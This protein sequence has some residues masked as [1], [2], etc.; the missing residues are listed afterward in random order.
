MGI[1]FYFSNI[2]REH[3]DIV[4]STIKPGSKYVFLDFN[5]AIHYCNNAIKK[6]EDYSIDNHENMLITECLK[7]IDTIIEHSHCK[8]TLFVSI[9][10]VVPFSKMIQQRKRR[11]LSVWRNTQLKIN[12]WDSN[13]ISPGTAFMKR[14]NDALSEYRNAKVRNIIISDSTH[15]G[16]GEAKIFKFIKNNGIKNENIIIYGLDAD[17]IMLSLLQDNHVHLMRESEFYKFKLDSPFLYLDISMLKTELV[18]YIKMSMDNVTI[19]NHLQA[20][21]VLCYFIG[22][23]FIPSLSYLKIK[24]GSIDFMLHV[25]SKCIDQEGEELM[26]MNDD[27]GRWELNW[28]VF[29]KFI[30]YLVQF[31]DHEF[32]KNHHKYYNYSRKYTD[33]ADYYD[34]YGMFNKPDD[35]IRPNEDGW[36]HR[37]YTSLFP[38]MKVDSICKNYIEGIKW[39]IQYYFN[40]TC[41]T[42]WYYKYDYS[43]TLFD[44]SNYMTVNDVNDISYDESTEFIDSSKHL[45]CILPK[46]SHKLLCDEKKQL[47]ET[48]KFIKY[49]PISYRIQTYLKQYLHDCIPLIPHMDFEKV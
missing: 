48:F 30:S 26:L 25:L 6:K 17:L 8:D 7:Y 43:P 31:E 41:H 1:P 28:I 11:Y 9:D 36:R 47:V 32:A 4:K 18:K 16:E 42:R 20:Y 19:K 23:D 38:N 14:L 15:P 37:Y 39:N 46:A 49:Y 27:D 3:N 10:G 21:V 40:D 35:T 24:N 13:A 33:D 22:N 34:N 2:T 12:T 29:H 44:L 45:M 5:C